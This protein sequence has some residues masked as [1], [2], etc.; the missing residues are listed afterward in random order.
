MMTSMRV[1]I[2]DT[3]PEDFATCFGC[4]RDNEHG[5]RLKTYP[6]GEQAVTD[7]EPEPYYTGGGTSAYGGVIAS[8]IDCHSAGAAAI[9]WM[10]ANGRPVGEEPAPRFVTARL[11]V[12]YIAPTPIGPLHLTG[13]AEEIGE[14]KVIVTTEL[15]ADGQ[16]T[17]RGRAVMVR[18]TP[19]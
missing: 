2:Q 13:A 17:A 8:L 14:R 9:F 10:K 6:D 16:V 5:H 19:S 1:S 3:Y 4:G 18:I 11:E 7:H 12:D 15:I